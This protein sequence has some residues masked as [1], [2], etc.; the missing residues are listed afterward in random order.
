MD[1]FHDDHNI[2]THSTSSALLW[3][4]A[5]RMQHPHSACGT[6]KVCEG[7]LY[8]IITVAVLVGGCTRSSTRTIVALGAAKLIDTKPQ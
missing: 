8:T 4:L 3:V 2:E 1:P 7:V 5:D 6:S